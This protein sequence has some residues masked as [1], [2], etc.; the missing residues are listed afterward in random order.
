[1][2]TTTLLCTPGAQKITSDLAQSI[3]SAWGG[4]SIKWLAAMEAVEFEI[5]TQPENLWQ[6]WAEMQKIGIDLIVQSS[7]SRRKKILLADMDSTMIEQECIDELAI[8]AGV[9]TRVAGVT[10][11]AMNGELDFEQA[12]NERVEL[13]RGLSEEIIEQ[14]YQKRVTFMPGSGAL[15]ATHRAHEGYA[16]LVSGG[17]TDFTQRVAQALGFNEH[18]ANILLK[19]N[20][21][22]TG[23]VSNPILGREAKVLALKEIS[24][25]QG[26]TSNDVLAV[27]DGANDLGM[28]KIAGTGVALHSKPIVQDQV[29]VRIN[30]GDLTG[31]LYLQG[32]QKSEFVEPT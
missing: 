6:V 1:M 4:R 28:L 2:F 17:F 26:L 3:C 11:R 32:F 21:L 27:G 31:L 22:L 23:Q 5:L 7:E 9:G 19:I 12:L 25:A 10:A 20:G 18:R 14:V 29:T 16:A 30:H 8:E 15:L 13:L 24:I